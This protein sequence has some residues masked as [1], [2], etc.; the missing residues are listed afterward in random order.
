MVRA[1]QSSQR[2]DRAGG[3]FDIPEHGGKEA[4]DSQEPGLDPY[5]QEEV[6]CM[7]K[8]RFSVIEVQ[9]VNKLLH[10]GSAS[11]APETGEVLM[12]SSAAS[13]SGRRLAVEVSFGFAMVK[14]RFQ[15]VSGSSGTHKRHNAAKSGMSRGRHKNTITAMAQAPPTQL[16]RE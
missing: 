13:Y 14:I 4:R 12:T 11:P 6:V 8:R 2:A 3:P 15:M 9:I 7:D 16:A 5:L 10:C 1:A